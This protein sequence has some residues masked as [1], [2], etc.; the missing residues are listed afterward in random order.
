MNLINDPSDFDSFARIINV[1][2]REINDTVLNQIRGIFDEVEEEKDVLK[3]MLAF[4]DYPNTRVFAEVRKNMVDF[5]EL[6]AQLR[7]MVEEKVILS[8]MK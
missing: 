7:R 5:L 4:L 2:N 8:I 3:S 1:P 6:F